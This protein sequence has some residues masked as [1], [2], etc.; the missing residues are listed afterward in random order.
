MKIIRKIIRLESSIII[1]NHTTPHHTTPHPSDMSGKARANE[2]AKPR[3][4]RSDGVSEQRDGVSEQLVFRC[5]LLKQ[6]PVCCNSFQFANNPRVL[7]VTIRHPDFYNTE[8]L[9]W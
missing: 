8:I 6:T 4:G 5:M 9:L 3:S 1:C 2:I 7:E